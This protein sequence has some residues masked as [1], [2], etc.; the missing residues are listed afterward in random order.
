MARTFAQGIRRKLGYAQ[1]QWIGLWIT[2]FPMRDERRGAHIL[3][4]AVNGTLLYAM[5]T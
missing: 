1:I 3:G 5:S 4:T 2:Y